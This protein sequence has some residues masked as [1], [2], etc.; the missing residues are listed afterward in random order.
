M[1]QQRLHMPAALSVWSGALMLWRRFSAEHSITAD[2]EEARAIVDCLLVVT[3]SR[4][5]R[6][7]SSESL[8]YESSRLLYADLRVRHED[9][10]FDCLEH[11]HVFLRVETFPHQRH[12]YCVC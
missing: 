11:E 1:V 6:M 2:E 9:D 5:L 8:F 3:V 10:I 7:D 4:V 12:V